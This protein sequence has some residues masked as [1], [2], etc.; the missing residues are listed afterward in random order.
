MSR[1][2]GQMYRETEAVE[3]DCVQYLILDLKVQYHR[4]VTDCIQYLMMDLQVQN[5]HSATE[6]VQYLELDLKIV[7]Y[8]QSATICLHYLMV[9]LK[10][11]QDLPTPKNGKVHNSVD[12]RGASS[13]HSRF[14]G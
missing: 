10:N 6:C 5:P 1:H 7:Q 4:S 2:L 14:R 9:N 12:L 13:G 8:H 11:V 3:T